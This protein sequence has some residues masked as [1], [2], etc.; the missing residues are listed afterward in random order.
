MSPV[1][2]RWLLLL[3]GPLLLRPATATTAW[4]VDP[5]TRVRP[6]DAPRSTAEAVLKAARNESEAFQIVVRAGSKGV[7]GG[8]L[9]ASDLKGDG[10]RVIERRHVALFREQYLQIATPSP[11]SKEG[12]GIYPDALIPIGAEPGA[13]PAEKAPRFIG[14]PF[15]IPPD[16]NQPFWVEVR[17]PK[18]AAPGD[19]AGSITVSMQDEK[20]LVVPV[21]LT[22]WDFTL[23]DTPSLRTNFGGLGRRLLTG[24]PGYK[25]DTPPYR[26]LERKYAEAMAAHRLCPPVPPYLRPKEG[27]DGTV[28]PKESHAALKE[29]IEAFHLTGFEIKLIGEDPA[30]K[31]RERNVKMLQ[32]TWAYLKENGWEKLAYVWAVDEPNSDKM[33]EEVRRRAKMIHEAQ[34]GLKVLCTEQPTPQDASWGTLAGSVDIW[35]PLWTLFDEKTVAE[36]QKAG[37]EVWSYTALCQGKPGGDAPYWEIDFPLLN[38]RIPAWTSR[39]YGLTGLLY[40]TVVYWTAGDVWANPLTFNRQ[41]NGEGSLFYP[42][43]DAGV[44]GPVASMRLKALRDGLE[45]YEYLLLAGEAGLEKAAR[46]APSWGSWETKPWNLAAAR[47]ELA[48]IILAK[49]K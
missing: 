27:A 18:D 8:T 28:D 42:G 9:E 5:L 33:Y 14:S 48:Q 24:H 13:K 40:W 25:P 20:P 11:R 3:L 22:V 4:V 21:T 10:G 17:V 31:D 41:F 36:R 44:E 2:A 37:E 38:Y 35:V 34:P 19:Y 47:E 23:P 7:K 32:S 26:A 6:K 39:R 12:P 45:D 16:F 15:L 1:T 30:G 49:K 43:G 29:W 46:M